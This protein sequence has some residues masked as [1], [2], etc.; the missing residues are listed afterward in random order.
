MDEQFYYLYQTNGTLTSKNTSQRWTRFLLIFPKYPFTFYLEVLLLQPLYPFWS[1]RVHEPFQVRTHPAKEGIREKNIADRPLG[2]KYARQNGC[3]PPLHSVSHGLFG[4]GMIKETLTAARE[5]RF[6]ELVRS[7]HRAYGQTFEATVTGRSIIFTVE[8]KNVQTV[9]ATKF[10]DFELGDYRKM[11]VRPLLGHGIFASDGDM[12]QRSR[13]LLLP[14]FVRDQV[15]DINVYETHVARLI[16]N[17]PQDGST[18]DL[19]DLFFRMVTASLRYP[20]LLIADLFMARPSTPPR[21]SSLGSQSTRSP[22]SARPQRR[23]LPRIWSFLR[24]DWPRA[25]GLDPSCH[26]TGTSGSPNPSLRHAVM[27]R[28]S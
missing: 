26:F 19:Q 14:H 8:P 15:K 4:L 23:P 22:M 3:R 10:E 1:L 16:E 9:L 2:W 11:A 5:N 21:N 13:G 12:W 7:W 20:A 18:V 27:L 25:L 6:L 17:I 28:G 24:T